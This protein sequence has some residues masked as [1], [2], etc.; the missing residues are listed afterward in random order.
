MSVITHF[1]RLI[2]FLKEDLGFFYH[3]NAI[4]LLFFILTIDFLHPKGIDKD[5]NHKDKDRTLL[6]HP[7]SQGNLTKRQRIERLYEQ[8]AASDGNPCPNKE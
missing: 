2:W 5:Q 3:K 7:K 4:E 6:R 8:N 1:V